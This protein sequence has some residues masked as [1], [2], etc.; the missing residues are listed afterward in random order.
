MALQITSLLNIP[1]EILQEILAYTFHGA[2]LHV[3][4]KD[5]RHL[6][7]RY[8]RHRKFEL[9]RSGSHH[10][11]LLTC[12]RLYREGLNTYYR[13]FTLYTHNET[14]RVIYPDM[15]GLGRVVK[16]RTRSIISD[17]G[18]FYFIGPPPPLNLFPI[19]KHIVC[20][21]STE[22]FGVIQGQEL[23]RLQQFIQTDYC[24][25]RFE[26]L[27]AAL[28]SS[29]WNVKRQLNINLDVICHSTLHSLQ[30]RDFVCC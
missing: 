14:S 6:R 22:L 2:E 12:K 8:P 7:I 17:F 1:R 28:Q 26:G 18:G 21:F 24:F 13:F 11:V 29:T 5:G 19:V 23:A 3:E 20:K 27:A 25:G 30:E 9:Q 16:A 4:A 15:S 10:N